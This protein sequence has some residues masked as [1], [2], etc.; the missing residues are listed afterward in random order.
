VLVI[1]SATRDMQAVLN[2]VWDHLLPALEGKGVPE[3]QRPERLALTPPSGPAPAGGDGRTYRFAAGNEIGLAAVRIDP[4][5]TGTFSFNDLVDGSRHD[6][7]CAAGDWREQSAQG[8]VD[9]AAP[10]V[11][12]RV[13]TSAYGDGDAFVATL[14]WL[15]SP[16]VATL[17][18]RATGGTMTVDAELNVSFGPTEF[19]IVSEPMSQN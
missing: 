9:D 3:L 12:S 19:T 8:T 4:D 6:L 15:E 10:E 5:G 14:R 11:G 2:T 18:C 13:V 17:T 16:Y 7:V 1:T